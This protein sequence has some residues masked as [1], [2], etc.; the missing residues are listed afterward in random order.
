M[1]EFSDNL[2]QAVSGLNFEV[3]A[4]TVPDERRGAF[5]ISPVRR[6]AGRALLRDV[7][8]LP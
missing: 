8:I 1:S 6:D 3:S 4:L 2:P 7:C 5:C